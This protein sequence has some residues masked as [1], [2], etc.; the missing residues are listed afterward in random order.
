MRLQAARSKS[1]EARD[2]LI[3]EAKRWMIARL[4]QTS[5]LAVQK[6]ASLLP[7]TH[8]PRLPPSRITGRAC[9]YR[10]QP[11]L[12]PH[13]HWRVTLIQLTQQQT[14]ERRPSSLRQQH[15]SITHADC[16]TTRGREYPATTNTMVSKILFWS[17]F[18][19]R[20]H[21]TQKQ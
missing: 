19:T 4:I 12:H 11:H 1:R 20:K 8:V 2:G 14:T 13:D 18:G 21:P 9:L 17:G 16:K 15:I 7:H 3:A 10:A 5:E 6:S